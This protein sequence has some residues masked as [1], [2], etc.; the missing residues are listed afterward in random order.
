MRQPPWH[1]AETGG[2]DK[3][4]LNSRID[5]VDMGIR[6]K[7]HPYQ[8]GHVV[9]TPPATYVLK[10]A[11][12]SIFCKFLKGVKFPDGF[13]DNLGSYITADGS[14]VQGWIKTH[15]CQVLLQRIIPAGLTGLCAP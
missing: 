9:K 14:K 13:A 7:L 1:T 8:E 6:P 12:R 10:T 15:S 3:G 11:Q 5:L 4:T 2:Q